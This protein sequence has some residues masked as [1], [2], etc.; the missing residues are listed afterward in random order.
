ML[1]HMLVAT[2]VNIGRLRTE[3]SLTHRE[4]SSRASLEEQAQ[5]ECFQRV[6]ALG[7]RA[8]Y[9]G[10]NVSAEEIESVVAAGRSLNTQLLAAADKA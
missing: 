9:G 10:G 4:L 3:R 2:L 1:L 7:E 5:R 6:A 8:V